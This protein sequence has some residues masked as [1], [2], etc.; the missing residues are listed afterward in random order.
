MKDLILK[1]CDVDFQQYVKR[2][3]QETDATILVREPSRIIDADTGDVLVIYSTLSRESQELFNA[4]KKVKYPVTERTGGLKTTSRIFG[5]M[6]RIALRSDFCRMAGLAKDEPMANALLL[7]WGKEAEK[8]Y[9]EFAP[10][11]YARHMELTDKVLGEYR[12]DK[13]VFTSGIVNKN[14]P[15]KYHFDSGNFE[16]VF[17]CMIGFKDGVLGGYLA[18]PEYNVALEIANFSVSLFDGQNIIH[19]VTPI[20]KLH[21]DATRF[22]VVFY[23]LKQLWNCKPLSEE[24]ARIRKLKRKRHTILASSCSA[25]DG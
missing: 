3:A 12:M 4:L 21:D 15:L 16:D 14:N 25:A 20:T 5:A 1:R 17:S 18:M 22:T 24:L 13:T 11:R 2:S 7:K 19:G 23:S 10:D 8:L 6:P 9:Q